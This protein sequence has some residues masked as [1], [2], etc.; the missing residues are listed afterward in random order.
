MA[1]GVIV[2]STLC[3][4]IGNAP[5]A[6]DLPARITAKIRDLRHGLDQT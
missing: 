4:V 1:D 6:P 2:G 3:R 5:T